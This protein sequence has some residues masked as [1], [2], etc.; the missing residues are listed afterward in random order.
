[1]GKFKPAGLGSVNG[2][3]GNVVAYDLN[4]KN[5][6]RGIGRQ[7][8]FTKKQLAVQERTQLLGDI[9]GPLD[10]FIRVGFHNIPKDWCCT[11]Q[12][13]AFKLNNPHAIAGEYPEQFVDFSKLI[14]CKGKLPGVKQPAVKLNGNMID[15]SWENN[16]AEAGADEEDQLMVAVYFPEMEKAMSV[17]NGPARKSGHYQLQLTSHVGDR[18]MEIFMAFKAEDRSDVSD[19]IYAGRLLWTVNPGNH[20]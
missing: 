11:Y 8:P 20:G 18:I 17:Q 19:S 3:C 14:L 10:A 2:K 6:V 12:N 4:G 5:V 15:F 13:T 7:G 1:M 16:A 9:F